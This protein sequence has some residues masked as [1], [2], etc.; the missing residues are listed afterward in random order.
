MLET[1]R[2]RAIRNA[3]LFNDTTMPFGAHPLKAERPAYRRLLVSKVYP[4]RKSFSEE[5][6][7]SPHRDIPLALI[8]HGGERL[9][10]LQ[11][12]VHPCFDC[13]IAIVQWIVLLH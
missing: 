8:H 11:H 12:L 10:D 7:H 5:I 2:F 6:P 1:S 9:L 13:E 3:P 4:P